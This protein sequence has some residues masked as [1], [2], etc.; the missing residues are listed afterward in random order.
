MKALL[1]N[2][3]VR[4]ELTP[5]NLARV[6]H[7]CTHEQISDDDFRFLTRCINRAYCEED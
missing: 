1:Q 2:P 4:A 7:V 3:E 5:T 6:D